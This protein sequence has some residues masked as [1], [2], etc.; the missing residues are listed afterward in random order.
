MTNEFVINN[1]RTLWQDHIVETGTL[2]LNEV[3]HRAREFQKATRRW[4]ALWYLGASVAAVSFARF[5]L[6]HPSV[7]ARIGAGLG[8]A[9]VCLGIYLVHKGR[10]AQV[11]P[12]AMGLTTCIIFHRTGLERQRDF[13]LRSWRYLLLPIPGA[14]V[15]AIGVARSSPPSLGIVPATLFVPLYA[16]LTLGVAKARR[17]HAR[18]LQLEIDAL[19]TAEKEW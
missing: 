12:E 16:A 14:V 19:N 8:L 10:S 5:L 2:P 7:L 4:N 13:L 15:F 18:R 3:R 9:A 17:L 1:I 11:V 6:L